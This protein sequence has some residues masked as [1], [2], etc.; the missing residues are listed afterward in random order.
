ML[1]V[2]DR[3]GGQR[4]FGRRLPCARRS[5]LLRQADQAQAGPVAH[6][7]MRLF[8]QD[9]LDHLGGVRPHFPCPV[10][11]AR[12]RPLQMRLMSSWDDARQP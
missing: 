5:S 4:P 8:G 6:L 10:H 12:G 2:A 9:A 7:R 11:H 3:A 1:P